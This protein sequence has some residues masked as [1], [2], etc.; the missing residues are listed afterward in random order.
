MASAEGFFAF[1]RSSSTL[2]AFCS[3]MLWSPGCSFLFDLWF[4]AGASFQAWQTKI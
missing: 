1:A 4:C 2:I 3:A